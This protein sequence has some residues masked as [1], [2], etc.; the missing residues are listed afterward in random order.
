MA[1][2]AA[3]ACAGAILAATMAA[4]SS[5]MAL[6]SLT[7]V[8][9]TCSTGP[10][11]SQSKPFTSVSSVRILSLA[12]RGTGYSCGSHQQKCPASKSTPCAPH[13]GACFDVN[14]RHK[15]VLLN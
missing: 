6:L 10:L 15:H 9:A 14:T 4:R 13:A 2:A 7:S 1:A 11:G 12:A 5:A 8:V 3:G